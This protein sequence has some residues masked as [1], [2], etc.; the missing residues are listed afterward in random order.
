MNKFEKV[1]L[2]CAKDDARKGYEFAKIKKSKRDYVAIFKKN[3]YSFNH[4]VGF[5]RWN[6][7][8]EW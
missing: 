8:I 5:K 6:K 3:K 1:A 7:L 4:V 2:Q